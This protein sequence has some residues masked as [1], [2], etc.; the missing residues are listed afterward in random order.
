MRA[1]A[2]RRLRRPPAVLSGGAIAGAFNQRCSKYRRLSFYKRSLSLGKARRDVQQRTVSLLLD[3]AL[4]FGF[5]AQNASLA[6]VTR[7]D[8]SLGRS[9]DEC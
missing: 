9:W 6:D 5:A 1:S 3:A 4:A 7:K 8:E 2:T